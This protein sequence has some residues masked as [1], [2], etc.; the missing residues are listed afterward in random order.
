[1]IE[2]VQGRSPDAPLGIE[3]SASYVVVKKGPKTVAHARAMGARAMGN[4]DLLTKSF[5]PGE[6]K[7]IAFQRYCGADACMSGHAEG[8]RAV[9]CSHL[10]TVTAGE[11]TQVEIRLRTTGRGNCR[12]SAL[13]L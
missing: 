1:M 7:V 4:V 9:Q 11:T 3:G 6:Y 5:A 13:D 10:A 8:P 12:V 2:I